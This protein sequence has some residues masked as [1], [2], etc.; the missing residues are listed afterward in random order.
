MSPGQKGQNRNT[1]LAVKAL[2]TGEEARRPAH[3][4][5]GRMS[6]AGARPR[7]QSPT[8][9]YQAPDIGYVWGAVAHGLI[10]LH[11]QERR[12]SLHVRAAH[13]SLCRQH[14]PALCFAHS[15]SLPPVAVES[16]AGGTRPLFQHGAQAPGTWALG[17]Q[18]LS[19]QRPRGPVPEH[20]PPGPQAAAAR[21]EGWPWPDTGSGCGSPHTA[22]EPPLPCD[23][24]F[25]GRGQQPRETGTEEPRPR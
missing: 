7:A 23:S 1:L 3:T 6:G 16:A 21:A 22:Q 12:T 8:H 4:P 11:L 10:L 25:G 14:R 17:H 20:P 15:P 5:G 13:G 19:Q 9:L 2:R 24:N 18:Q